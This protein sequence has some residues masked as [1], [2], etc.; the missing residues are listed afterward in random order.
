MVKHGKSYVVTEL[1]GDTKIYRGGELV[2]TFPQAGFQVQVRGKCT[3]L[4]GTELAAHALAEVYLEV[5]PNNRRWVL[6]EDEYEEHVRVLEDHRRELIETFPFTPEEEAAVE[7]DRQKHAEIEE[8]G[9][10][11]IR[12][13]LMNLSPYKYV[14]WD[15][16][17]RRRPQSFPGLPDAEA[18]SPGMTR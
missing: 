5:D 17:P 7:T 13:G 8:R 11:T 15:P 14:I 3:A 10:E 1:T 2:G 12:R 18:A 16:N 4:A 6:T 9:R